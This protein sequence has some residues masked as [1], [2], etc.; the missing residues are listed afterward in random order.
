MTSPEGSTPRFLPEVRET[1][2]IPTK[3]CKTEGNPRATCA[4]EKDTGS[5]IAHKINKLLNTGAVREVDGK[6][7]ELLHIHPLSVATDLSLLSRTTSNKQGG[8]S[9][10]QSAIGRRPINTAGTISS[11]HVVLSPVDKRNTRAVAREVAEAQSEQG[12][13]SRSWPKTTEEQHTH[14]QAHQEWMPS[15]N[16][17]IGPVDLCGEVSGSCQ[18]RNDG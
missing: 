14:V 9:Q 5:R 7:R 12:H 1:I 17:S 8:T 2:A 13:L 11:L 18:P 6:A 4:A 10:M 3:R 15:L 16:T